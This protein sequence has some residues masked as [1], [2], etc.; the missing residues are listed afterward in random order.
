MLFICSLTILWLNANVSE[1]GATACKPCA[2][3]RAKCGVAETVHQ[4]TRRKTSRKGK[5]REDPIEIDI[6]EVSE[7]EQYAQ[8]NEDVWWAI[9]SESKVILQHLHEGR[10]EMMA[11]RMAVEALYRIKPKDYVPDEAGVDD[12]EME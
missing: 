4:R 8:V 1:S 10:K 7:E 12:V 6:A 9:I 3:A 2:D 5:S 11:L